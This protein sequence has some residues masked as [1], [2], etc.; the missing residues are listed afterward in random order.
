[1]YSC[2]QVFISVPDLINI[3]AWNYNDQIPVFSSTRTNPAGRSNTIGIHAIPF[4][5]EWDTESMFIEILVY[6][7]QHIN[8]T[9]MRRCP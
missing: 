7:V 3:K 1:M 8:P 4:T 9:S 5:V 6:P 2:N